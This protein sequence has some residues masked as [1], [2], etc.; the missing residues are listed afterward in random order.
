MSTMHASRK[1]WGLSPIFL[2]VFLLLLAVFP[3]MGHA[4]ISFV[5]ASYPAGV[6]ATTIPFTKPAGVQQYDVM[7]VQLTAQRDTTTRTFTPPSGWVSVNRQD[8]G[9]DLVQEVFWKAAGASEPA[10]YTFT[11]N[12]L[13][14]NRVSGGLLAYR[15]VSNTSPYTAAAGQTNALS[16]NVVAPSI[17]TLVNDALLVGFFGTANGNGS[18]TPPP[19]MTERGD[20]NTG[21][22]NNGT[23][24]E[25][26]DEPRPAAGLTGTRTATA[27]H[28]ARN[29]GQLVSL[30]PARTFR[31]EAAATGAIGT[32]IAG[33][34][35]NIRITALNPNG[36]TDTTF[37][38]TVSISSTG[39]L[40][41]GSGTTV[42][43]T[44]GVL[45]SH[46]V[47]ISNT[48]TFNITA[49]ETLST[50]L[51][52][53]NDFLVVPRLQILV[54]GE[55]AAPG[56]ASGKTGTPSTQTPGTAFNV[57][58]NAVDE[59]WNLVATA[60]DTITLTSSDGAAVLP[61]A[62]AL[63]SGTRV[64]SVTLN[65]PPS[66]TVTANAST[67]ARANTSSAIPLVVVVG[68]FNAYETSTAAGAITGVIRTKVAGTA[69]NLDLIALNAAKTAI[70]TTFT[71][72]V[73]VELLNS[74]SGGTLDANGCNAGWPVIQT[75][76]TSP[77][78]VAGNN[79]RKT[80]SFQENNAWR[81]VRV[82][83]SF[84]ATG[85]A[86]GIGCSSNSFAIRPNAFASVSVSDQDWQTAGITRTLT[87]TGA[88]G[89][90]VHKAGQPFTLRATAV[91]AVAVT[92]TNYTDTPSPVL[93]A[94]VDTGC[95]TTFG[96]FSVG[97]AAVSGVINST[98]ASY[99]EVGAFALQLQDQAF[100]SVDAGDTAGDCS[101][102]GRYVC[103]ASFNVGRFVPDHFVLATAGSPQFKT[104]NDTACATRSFTYVGQKFGYLARPQATIT[105]RNA[106][107]GTTVNYAGTNLWKLT[108]AGV[109][110]TYAAATGTLDTGLLGA[111][112]VSDTGSGTGTLAANAADEI[113]FV[114][115]APV[116]PFMAAISL[117]MSIRDSS[118]SGVP[119]NGI[120]ETATP[121]LFSNISFDS[122]NE[123][124]F[125]RLVLSNAHGSELLGLP[126]PIET[127]FWTGSGFSRN[128]ADACTQL[129]ATHVAL[130]N[131]RRDLN[132]CETSVT[133]SGRFNSGRGNL[134]L[135]KPGAG[136]TGSV[137]LTLL[138]GATGAG[139]T[140][141]AGGV[142]AAGAA[143]Q[144]WLQGRWSG[145]AYDQNPAARGSFGLHRG[146]KPLI[147]FREM[148]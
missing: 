145:A 58:V 120:I 12:S 7:L 85:T 104:F 50:N 15:G 6:N 35:F 93:S 97:S 107:G 59:F 128:T 71:G 87:N 137:D 68:S 11:M 56:T 45:A 84:P 101:A 106:A 2:M 88:S 112:V 69:F 27:T 142:S 62:A 21:A 83:I 52:V 23:T 76:A 30:R 77:V 9:T 118:E 89:G 123:I 18:F 103:S 40:S 4:A 53:S 143:S 48:G 60:T 119:G 110:Q 17:N 74:S 92:T 26:A 117:S 96:T 94:C 116:V 100:A 10:S 75:L 144:S 105:A 102:T 147:Y 67:P 127:Q 32:Q 90:N 132:A 37:T 33:T 39:S 72:T 55:T 121:V 99:S 16:T 3:L 114:R 131:W 20:T 136:N 95:I 135:S 82:R 36:T 146:S 108:F 125:G 8:N 133:L 14:N 1:K 134:K 13:S 34:S 98:T 80:V 148:Y 86:T 19:G 54:P 70:L 65:T 66:Q 64:F 126:V 29:I 124:R 42:A 49:T 81:N 109:T 61:A 51:G 41:A 79:G 47:R 31:V 38:G 140:C 115:S 113:A 111:P 91:N 78:F 5:G 46:T 73:K 43:F 141:M 138:L 25:A 129:A 24:A 44:S 63:V 57:T 122:G 28:S 130:T 139:S 22:G